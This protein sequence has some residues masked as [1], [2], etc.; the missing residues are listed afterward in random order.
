[1]STHPFDGLYKINTN[2]TALG[3]VNSK[4]DG[5][6]RIEK[7]KTNRVDSA[8]C[9][10]T[11]SFDLISQGI[12]KMT[13][14]ADLSE[15]DPGFTLSPSD[16]ME[17]PSR[18]RQTYETLLDVEYEAGKVVQMSGQI[19]ANGIVVYLSLDRIGD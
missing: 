7:S 15:A 11:S 17:P 10:W 5:E 18:S 13:S 3:F 9:K 1:M 6:T 8:N 16:G 2:S 19:E 12:V 14:I 4:S